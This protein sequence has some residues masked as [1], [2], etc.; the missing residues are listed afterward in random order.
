MGA[1]TELQNMAHKARQCDRHAYRKTGTRCIHIRQNTLKK[2]KRLDLCDRQHWPA[3]LCFRRPSGCR[4]ASYVAV[5]CS[6]RG[7]ETGYFTHVSHLPR[8]QHVLGH[9]RFLTQLPKKTTS[10]CHST[11]NLI[12]E[13][14]RLQDNANTLVNS[15]GTSA[16]RPNIAMA[17]WQH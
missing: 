10:P 9:E 3:N 16:Q 15:L 14:R 1:S 6:N 7:T 13:W 11:Y 12:Q 8:Q 5:P 2:V 4:T 17:N